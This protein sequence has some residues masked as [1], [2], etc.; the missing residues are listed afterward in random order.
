MEKD[1]YKKLG[2]GVIEK[3]GKLYKYILELKDDLPVN[4]KNI[5]LKITEEKPEV[6][7]I[8]TRY[9]P[10]IEI[11]GNK[12]SYVNANLGYSIKEIKNT[13]KLFWVFT[14]SPLIIPVLVFMLFAIDK[15]SKPLL[16]P[17]LGIVLII[18]VIYSIGL[19][20]TWFKFLA[21]YFTARDT[22]KMLK[23]HGYKDGK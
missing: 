23:S 10:E 9:D 7:K 17:S 8:R 14:L 15:I 6:K 11:F 21:E 19:I 20:K 3:P 12:N 5:R 4:E 16:F 2:E 18:F 13:M 22:L 1:S